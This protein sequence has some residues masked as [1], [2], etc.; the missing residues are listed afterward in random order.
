MVRR[1]ADVDPEVAKVLREEA[2][3]QHHNLELIASENFVSDAVLEATGSVLTNKYAEGYPGRRYYGGCEVVDVV[4]D[5]A[6]ARAKQLFGAEHV[7]VQPHSGAQANMAVYF[8]LLKPGDVVLGPN[9]SHGGHLT[10]GSPVNYSGKFYSI[11]AYGVRRDTERIDLDQVRD[12]AKEH[13][14]KL[15]IAGGSA[16][17]RA[18]DFQPFADIAREVGATLMADIAHPAGLVAAGLHPSPVGLADFVTS[19]THKTLRGPRGG[20]VMCRASHAAALDKTVMPGVQGG[21]LMHVI[22]AK[23]VAFRE[24]LTPEWRAYQQQIVRNAKALA[25]ALLARGHR[26]VTGGTDTHLLLLD[27]SPKNITGKDAQ[28]ALDRAWIT[29]N[30]NTI[31]FETKSPMVTSGIRIG[32]PA[33]TTRGMKEAEMATIAEL[34]DRVLASLGVTTVEARVRGE[35]QELTG[36]FPLY[37]DRVK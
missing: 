33:V 22:A 12:L 3:R 5:L 27:L 17:P 37:P 30:K 25:D 11:V 35:V 29:V 4:E 6:I 9:L 26:L 23:A 14:P 20:M 32:T 24:A 18:I 31:P 36:R 7:N 13:R 2:Q 19:T 8:T 21:P 28:E 15:L 16:F 34:I 1:L 10:A